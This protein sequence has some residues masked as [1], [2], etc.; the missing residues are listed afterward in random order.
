MYQGIEGLLFAA[1]DAA[2]IVRGFQLEGTA[3]VFALV[4]IL[5]AGIMVLQSIHYANRLSAIESKLA[6]LAN[7]VHGTGVR[8]GI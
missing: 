5:L 3:L 8:T 2:P 4:F 6:E 1:E 7:T